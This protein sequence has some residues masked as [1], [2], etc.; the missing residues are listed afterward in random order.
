MAV[1]DSRVWIAFIT[2]IIVFVLYCIAVVST[3]WESSLGGTEHSG[4][5]RQ[6]IQFGNAFACN[7]LPDDKDTKTLKA[8]Y[9]AL[10]IATAVSGV[11]MLFTAGA[12]LCG[13]K[14]STSLQTLPGVILG[15]VAALGG[16]LAFFLYL[17]YEQGD[18]SQYDSGFYICLGAWIAMLLNWMLYLRI[19]AT[20]L[21]GEAARPLLG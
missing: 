20:G 4:L 6:C 12:G 21:A 18:S 14:D 15:F 1:S 11:L 8:A 10:I 13:A 19:R 2:N 7:D 9:G 16:G 5:H 17:G 3:Y